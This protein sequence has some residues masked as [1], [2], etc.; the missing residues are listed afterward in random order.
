[1]AIMFTRFELDNLIEAHSQFGIPIAA[2]TPLDKSCL[3]TGG[4]GGPR[5]TG[6]VAGSLFPS[7]NY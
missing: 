5:P 3:S 4:A 2:G 1:M 7:I 6:V